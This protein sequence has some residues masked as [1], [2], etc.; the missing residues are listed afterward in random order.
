MFQPPTDGVYVMTVY[1]VSTQAESG[2]MYIKTNDDILCSAN[3]THGDNSDTAT[4]TAIVQLAIGDSVRVTGESN[5]PGAIQAEFSGF[6]GHIISLS[7]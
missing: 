5:N 2:P 6:T 4:C 3:V 7:A 1:S